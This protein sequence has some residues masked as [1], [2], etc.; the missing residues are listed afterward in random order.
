M[1]VCNVCMLDKKPEVSGTSVSF[2]FLGI[3][4]FVDYSVPSPSS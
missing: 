3:S 2:R 4:T 1:Y